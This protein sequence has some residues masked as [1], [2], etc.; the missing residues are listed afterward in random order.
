MTDE[1]L[2]SNIRENQACY[3]SWIEKPKA[4]VFIQMISNKDREFK[5]L[6]D[7]DWIPFRLESVA[8]M[9]IFFCA[10]WWI[11]E[12]PNSVFTPFAESNANPTDSERHTLGDP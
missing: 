2:K 7:F 3:Q 1:T 4:A 9:S 11:G 6:H 5:H 8:A 10:T 12:S